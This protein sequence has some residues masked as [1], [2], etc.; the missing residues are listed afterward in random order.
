MSD[1]EEKRRTRERAVADVMRAGPERVVFSA[2]GEATSSARARRF[3][4]VIPDI[5]FIR[6]DGWTLG[7]PTRF[8][9]IAYRLWSDEWVGFMRR[10]NTFAQAMS[11][12]R[13]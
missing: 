1:T 4:N 3:H 7:A 10:P 2:A 9:D 11:E 13:P 6:A 8:E 12:Y 5:V